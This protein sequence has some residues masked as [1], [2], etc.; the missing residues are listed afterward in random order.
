MC[1]GHEETFRFYCLSFHCPMFHGIRSEPIHGPVT[2]RN[3]IPSTHFG[4]SVI[5]NR[6]RHAVIGVL[7]AHIFLGELCNPPLT[8]PTN[9]E[10]RSCD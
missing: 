9:F 5:F 7:G 6:R 3:A 4:R 10:L 2:V 1:R 8:P